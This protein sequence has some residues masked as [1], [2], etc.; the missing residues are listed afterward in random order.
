[1][2]AAAAQPPRYLQPRW[3]RKKQTQIAAAAAPALAAIWAAAEAAWR[4]AASMPCLTPAA[5][6]G[7]LMAVVAQAA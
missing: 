3:A 6:A 5:V 2:S 7:A 1:V 4:V